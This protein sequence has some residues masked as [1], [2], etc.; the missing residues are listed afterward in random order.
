[1]PYGSLYIEFVA[2]DHPQ[3]TAQE[4]A[5][6]GAGLPRFGFV[7]QKPGPGADLRRYAAG[8]VSQKAEA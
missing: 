3:R 4:L 5:P 6:E 8:F 2:F 1:M 7:D